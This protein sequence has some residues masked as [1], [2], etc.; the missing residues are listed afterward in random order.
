MSCGDSMK[1]TEQKHITK[2]GIVKNNPVKGNSSSKEQ[3]FA[4]YWYDK[5]GKQLSFNLYEHDEI[6]YEKTKKAIMDNMNNN[7]LF[8]VRNLFAAAGLHLVR[9]EWY[10]PNSYNFSGDSVDVVAKVYD[11]ERLLAFVMKHKPYLQKLLDS[12]KSY[13][14]YMALTSDSVD[15][16]I[17]KIKKNY[18]VDVMVI[19]YLL[20]MYPLDSEDDFY[21]LL[22]DDDEDVVDD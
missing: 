9:F 10:S 2:D 19:D 1:L 11:R 17:D 3:E 12:N 13:D 4:G 20:R 22:V 7:H 16:V 14:G 18:D 21:D 5:N 15:E 8:S 6:D